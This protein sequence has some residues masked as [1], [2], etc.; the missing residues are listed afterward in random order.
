M[1]RKSRWEP[2]VVEIEGELYFHA[3]DVKTFLEERGIIVHEII[4]PSSREE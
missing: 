2:R 1:E 3:E 4:N